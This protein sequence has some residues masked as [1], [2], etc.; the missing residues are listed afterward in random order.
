M[1]V[2]SLEDI[3]QEKRKEK[4]NIRIPTD[5]SIVPGP[6]STV[7][8]QCCRMISAPSKRKTGKTTTVTNQSV[9]DIVTLQK[10]ASPTFYLQ[11]E[12]SDQ[13]G[14]LESLIQASRETPLPTGDTN[15]RNPKNTFLN[16]KTG[17]EKHR[18]KPKKRK[19]A[20]KSIPKPKPNFSQG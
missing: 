18:P 13:K 4:K 8:F 2:P 1:L 20:R 9:G 17:S 19:T 11:R 5:N 3:Y 6:R 14:T 16:G 12:N 15:K 10:I 7:P